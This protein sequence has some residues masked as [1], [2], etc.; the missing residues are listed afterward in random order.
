MMRAVVLMLVALVAN[1]KGFSTGAA[2]CGPAP[3]VGGAHL[4]NVAPKTVEVLP[5]KSVSRP[6]TFSIGGKAIEI[7]GTATVNALSSTEVKINGTLVKGV[8][9]RLS[10][11]DGYDLTDTILPK[12]N[13]KIAGACTS[14]VVGI[15][16]TAA[17]DK[18]EV[19]GTLKFPTKSDTPIDVDVTVVFFNSDTR[20]IYTSAKFKINVGPCKTRTVCGSGIAGVINRLLNRC[21]KCVLVLDVLCKNELGNTRNMI[22]K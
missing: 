10:S 17:F 13:T 8:L 11:S 3:S 20:S 7:G 6:V 15:T 5:F 2:G 21:K 19:S 4:D 22:T 16:H 12:L 14:P 9:I 1:V 18:P